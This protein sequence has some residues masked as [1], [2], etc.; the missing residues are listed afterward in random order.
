MNLLVMEKNSEPISHKFNV[1]HGEEI[2]NQSHWKYHV[3]HCKY[4]ISLLFIYF[5]ALKL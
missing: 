1:C 5:M 2:Q 3:C 4:H